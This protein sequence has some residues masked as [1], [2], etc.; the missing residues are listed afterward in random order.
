M[1]PLETAN[2]R[3]AA[4]SRRRVID[5]ASRL[6]AERG[7]GDTT[8]QAIA[9]ASRV[10]RGSITWHFRSKDGLLFAVVDEVFRRWENEVLVPLL[11]SGSGPQRLAQVVAAHRDFVKAHP[12]VGRLF[13][14]LFFEAL[15]SRHALRE[16]YAKLHE[17]FRSYGRTWLARA[18]AAGTVPA[19]V[20]PEAA[21]AAIVGALGGAH[22]QWILD[23]ERVDID[24]V[25]AELAKILERGFAAATARAELDGVASRGP[26]AG[27][28]ATLRVRHARPTHRAGSPRAPGR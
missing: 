17:R 19:D 15:G 10:S 14:V 1:K 9:T 21:S 18:V 22:Y 26:S 8:L 12:Q 7:Y 5:A 3:R 25:E 20:N 16:H 11:G 6:F 28:A 27:A 24:A 13:F 23:P 2:A 4:A